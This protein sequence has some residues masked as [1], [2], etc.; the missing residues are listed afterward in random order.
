MS[1]LATALTWLIAWAPF[2]HWTFMGLH[3]IRAWRFLGHWPSYGRPDP[4]DLPPFLLDA[5]IET[6]AGYAVAVIAAVATTYATRR[7]RWQRRLL[8]AIAGV[9]A[10]WLA[11]FA[12]WYADPGG[13]VEWYAD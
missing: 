3:A 1:H 2:G 6:A 12:L 4:K 11:T 9:F 8:V 10:L 5:R 13:V 7:W